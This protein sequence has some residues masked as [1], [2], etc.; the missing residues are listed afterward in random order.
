MVAATPQAPPRAGLVRCGRCA[1]PPLLQPADAGLVVS[2][3]RLRFGFACGGAFV[4]ACPL[5][6]DMLEQ[7]AFE[8]GACDGLLVWGE[9]AHRL[10]LQAQIVVGAAFAVLEQQPIGGDASNGVRFE[11]H[12]LNSTVLLNTHDCSVPFSA[13]G[14]S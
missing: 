4:V 7:Q 13:A 14:A 6:R 9:L 11:W 2:A 5:P 1:Y 3:V 8:H 10:E 12:L